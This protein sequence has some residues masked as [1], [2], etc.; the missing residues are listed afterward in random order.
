MNISIP[1]DTIVRLS[2]LLPKPGA[3]VEDI[4][5]SIRLDH[6]RII[7]TDRMYAAVEELTPFK[8][9]YHIRL[10]DEILEQ[11]RIEAQYSSNLI[12]TPNEMIKWT[13]ARTTMGFEINESIGVWP[14]EPTTFDKWFE[15]L[16][17][18]CLTPATL[19]NGALICDADDIAR[20]AATSPSGR[21]IFESVIDTSR[22]TILRDIDDSRWVG[23]FWP[24]LHDGRYHAPASIPRWLENEL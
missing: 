6:G 22:P 12:V 14:T 23:F 24:K 17:R 7:V 5:H 1:C 16:V 11:C 9:V 15:K 13:V 21:I 4:F 3:D 10:P 2:N 8:G 18:P 19:T 20:L